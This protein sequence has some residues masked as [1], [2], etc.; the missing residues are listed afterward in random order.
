MNEDRTISA[1]RGLSVIIPAYNEIQAIQSELKKILHVMTESQMPFEVIVVDD[2]SQDGTGGTAEK[3][4]QVRVLHHRHNLGYG[5]ALKTGIRNA[6]YDV[7]CIIDA[8]GSYP[9]DQILPLTEKLFSEKCD[10]VVA[11]RT[12]EDVQIS[13]LRWPAKWFLNALANY[14]TGMKIPD[15]NSG[16]RVIR[17]EIVERF[18]N[19]LPQGFSFTTTI[20][21]AMLTNNYHVQF[22]P[23]NYYLRKGKSK[24]RPIYDTINFVQLIL[25][26]ILYFQPLKIFIPLSGLFFCTSV[27]LLLYRMLVEKAFVVTIV[28]LFV[29]SVQLFALG[30]IADM[31]N[32]R[33]K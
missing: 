27:L 31:I 19:I 24:I 4:P 26:T 15:L 20:T 21:L 22:V 2:G 16:L 18:L 17:K 13:L 1:L 23:T 28:I 33:M 8:D 5:A 32:K 25:R 3:V 6:V 12:G 11:A 14:L 10:M 9:V 30:M 29:T 7:V